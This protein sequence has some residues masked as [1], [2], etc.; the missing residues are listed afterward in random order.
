VNDSRP[1]IAIGRSRLLLDTIQ[2][3]SGHG[4]TFKAIITDQAYPEYDVGIDHFRQLAQELAAEFFV[5][6]S[7]NGEGSVPLAKLVERHGV[8]AAISVNWRFVIRPAV[9]DLFPLGILN[10]HLGRL[11]DYKGNATLNWAILRGEHEIFA[12]VHKMAPELDAGDVIARERLA[13]T[14]QTYVGELLEQAES[15][16]PQLFK[17]ALDRTFSDPWRIEVAGSPDGLRCFPRLPA[18]GEIDWRQ[19]AAAICRLVRASSRPYPG[20]FS[21][22]AGRKVIVWRAELAAEMD[23]FLA[24]PGHVTG[25]QRQPFSVRVACGDG[26]VDLTEMQYETGNEP[27][28]FGSIR[29]RFTSTSSSPRDDILIDQDKH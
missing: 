24:T 22:L 6:H 5:S 8:E 19:S 26:A 28:K 10:L 12:D 13:I 9:L 20:A 4:Y 23:P 29:L 27:L 3:L 16:A 11:P 14:D 25:W 15:L 2:F 18:D 1:L 7:L 17:T 21:F